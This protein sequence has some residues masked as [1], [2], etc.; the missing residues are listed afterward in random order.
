[1]IPADAPITNYAHHIEKIPLFTT[2]DI[3]YMT[4]G[5]SISIVNW[6]YSRWIIEPFL[7]WASEEPI[8]NDV[9]TAKL[10]VVANSLPQFIPFSDEV[11]SP[12]LAFL[13]CEIR[14][15]NRGLDLIRRQLN[16]PDQQTATYVWKDTVPPAWKEFIGYGGTDNI[17]TFLTLLKQKFTFYRDWFNSREFPQKIDVTFIR[18]VKG[19]LSSF[20]HEWAFEKGS[21][22]DSVCYE[23]SFSEVLPPR[24][25]ALDNLYLMGGGI[26]PQTH[27]LIL[28]SRNARTFMLMRP[29]VCAVAPRGSKGAKTFLVPLFRSIPHPDYV[30]ESD[31]KRIDGEVGNFVWYVPIQTNVPDRQLICEGA[32]LICHLPS[33]FV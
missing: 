26:D 1:M 31:Q 17:R 30:L 25:L 24:T 13:L 14:A 23:F 12:L 22:V 21:P 29:L 6:N 4:R 15:F 10:R 28:P 20:L 19:L 11:K 32:A 3:L 16:E 7:N 33:T 27:T 5:S 9:L 2:A 18:D 8:K